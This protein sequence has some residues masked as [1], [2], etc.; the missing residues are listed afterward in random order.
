MN[1][2][3]DSRLRG[4][5]RATCSKRTLQV[6]VGPVGGIISSGLSLPVTIALLRLKI[7]E[8]QTAFLQS[9]S[10]RRAFR[11]GRNRRRLS[12]SRA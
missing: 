1:G 8:I 7:R 5:L 3:G 12:R 9:D 4:T 11:I 10:A 6:C 2:T